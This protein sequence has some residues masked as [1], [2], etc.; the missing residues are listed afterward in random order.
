MATIDTNGALHDRLGQYSAK[1]QPAAG[2]D[3][4]SSQPPTPVPVLSVPPVPAD[5]LAADYQADDCAGV[6]GNCFA[7]VSGTV[8]TGTGSTHCLVEDVERAAEETWLEHA[9]EASANGVGP[10]VFTAPQVRRL[11]A[12]CAPTAQDATAWNADHPDARFDVAVITSPYAS[13]GAYLEATDRRTGVRLHTSSDPAGTT[14][15]RFAAQVEAE[16]TQRDQQGAT[17]QIASIEQAAA[18]DPYGPGGSLMAAHVVEDAIRLHPQT[19]RFILGDRPEDTD[20][21]GFRFGGRAVELVAA[22]PD[23]APDVRERIL[24]G[25]DRRGWEGLAGRDDLTGAE[26]RAL[27][28]KGR[29]NAAAVVMRGLDPARVGTDMRA[30]VLKVAKASTA[31]PDDRHA[32]N[33]ARAKIREFLDTATPEQVTRADLPTQITD[34]LDPVEAYGTEYLIANNMD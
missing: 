28:K 1:G 20:R 22:H 27:C 31:Y 10:G 7:P 2:Y 17:A 25:N 24:T 3:L 21:W 15:D 16:Y 26:I 9:F 13:I 8:H 29:E 4:G 34:R 14:L 12:H 18:E 30:T 6:C 5:M 33:A 23:L 19:Q 32:R 11:T